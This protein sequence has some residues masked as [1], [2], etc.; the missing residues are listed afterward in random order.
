MKTYLKPL[1]AASAVVWLAACQATATGVVT[2]GG[3]TA[4]STGPSMTSPPST[5]PSATPT[6]KPSSTPSSAPSSTPS[7]SPTPAL[8]PVPFKALGH[9]GKADEGKPLPVVKDARIKDQKALDAL[10]DQIKAPKTGRPTVDFTKKE[11]LAFYGAGGNNGCF[12][13]S[14]LSLGQD[15][16][17]ISPTL[18]TPPKAGDDRVCTEAIVPPSFLLI[19]IDK[20]TLPV[21][22]IDAAKP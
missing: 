8:T 15:G 18:S 9:F 10:L 5:T 2:P 17:I 20:S 4:P 7:A 11:V 3:S 14:L 13:L 1:L 12:E 21:A 22:G 16:K 19:E 6:T